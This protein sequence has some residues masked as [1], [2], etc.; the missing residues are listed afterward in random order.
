MGRKRHNTIDTIETVL[1]HDPRPTHPTKTQPK[2]M[3]RTCFPSIFFIFNLIFSWVG[4]SC[5]MMLVGFHTCTILSNPTE[6]GWKSPTPYKRTGITQQRA[7]RS[8]QAFYARTIPG[9]EP[10]PVPPH[11]KQPATS[12]YQNLPANAASGIPSPPPLYTWPLSVAR[13]YS[14]NDQ[15]FSPIMTRPTDG[16]NGSGQEV[17]K[18]S[19]VGS[20]PPDRI[21]LGGGDRPDRK[22]FLEITRYIYGLNQ[23]PPPHRS[24]QRWAT[25]APNEK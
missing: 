1:R 21:R 19:R 2:K 12:R 22:Q 9:C 17:L 3:V 5:V 20:D 11:R 24:P 15:A 8:P 18:K 7:F 4:W 13:T 6:V 10:E 14:T 25:T 23:S 16:W